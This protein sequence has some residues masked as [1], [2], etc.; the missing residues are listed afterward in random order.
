MKNATHHA[1]M[2]TFSIDGNAHQDE[3][4]ELMGYLKQF[5]I[6][7]GIKAEDCLGEGKVHLHGIHVR[8]FEERRPY[9]KERQV[10]QYGPRRVYDTVQH[11]VSKCPSIAKRIATNGSKHALRCDP[12]TSTKWVEYLNKETHMH[13]NNFP[14]DFC[15]VTQY[16]S[17]KAVRVA[18]P[19]LVADEKKYLELCENMS[20]YGWIK[21]P[22]TAKSCRR[23]YRYMMLV[24][25]EKRVCIDPKT[26]VKKGAALAM[27]MNEEVFSC[28]CS[29]SD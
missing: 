7:Y 6:Y 20:E 2:V 11:I 18:D 13:A 19:G 16:F 4:D 8:D 3:Y 9:D 23:F 12:I 1:F 27:F 21:L 15:L 5:G 24:A 10:D 14:N 17:E 26:I 28:S 22:A 29:D 25:R